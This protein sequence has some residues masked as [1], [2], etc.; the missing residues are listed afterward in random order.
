MQGG[1]RTVPNS[2]SLPPPSAA[3]SSA[4]RMSRFCG[5]TSQLMAKLHTPQSLSPVR[6]SRQTDA[7]LAGCAQCGNPGPAAAGGRAAPSSRVRLLCAHLETR[8][9][10]A[11]R[12]VSWCVLYDSEPPW[13]PAGFVFP[14]PLSFF[15]CLLLLWWGHWHGA[16]VPWC[17]SPR[18]V[19]VVA[20][21]WSPS[22][23]AAP[24]HS[25]CTG[26]EVGSSI[27]NKNKS[28][29]MMAPSTFFPF[30]FFLNSSYFIAL[31]VKQTRSY[32]ISQAKE[33]LPETVLSF[34]KKTYKTFIL[35]PPLNNI[36]PVL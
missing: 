32:I 35:Q 23:G 8:R 34:G 11:V 2:S 27:K 28:I 1:W 4:V 21:L 9:G 29:T 30:F 20:P 5:R 7:I 18:C 15:S 16:M 6:G 25:E 17:C 36:C 22:S 33:N 3:H 12:V 13:F 19:R 24:T 26:G 31:P 14:F 10:D